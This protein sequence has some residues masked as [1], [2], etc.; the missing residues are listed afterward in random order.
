MVARIDH[1]ARMVRAGAR[2]GWRT[3]TTWAPSVAGS[4]VAGGHAWRFI[5]RPLGEVMRRGLLKAFGLK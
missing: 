3:M 2:F 1:L 4:I 5:E